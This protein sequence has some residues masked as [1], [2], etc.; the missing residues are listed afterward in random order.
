MNTALPLIEELRA[1][2]GAANVRIADAQPAESLVPN[3]WYPVAAKRRQ[4]GDT[5]PAPLAL[6]SPA[7]A[8][9]VAAVAKWARGRGVSLLPV[10][11]DSNTVGSTSVAQ[12][13]D[14]GATVALSLSRLDT[15]SYDETELSVTAGAGVTLAAV[16][17]QLNA[18]GYTLGSLPQSARLATVGGAVATEAWGLLAA[19]FGGM[20]EQCLALEA[21][22]P[23]GSLVRTHGS[24]AAGRTLHHLLIGTEGA[25]GIVTAATLAMHALPE[26]RAWCAFA[27]PRFADAADALRL[28]YRSDARPAC[29]RLFDANAARRR[30]EG[31]VPDGSAL[32]LF[33]VEGSEIVQNGVY[34]TV[35]AVAK[36]VGGTET[37]ADGDAW[38]GEEQYRTDAW[39]ANGRPGGVADVIS[40]WTGWRS[41]AALHAALTESLRPLTTHIS[42][43]IGFASA[44]GAAL[45]V[46][47]E[48][49]ATSPASAIERHEQ[50]IAAAQR[51][52]L[53]HG[54]AVAHH[55]GIGTARA[56]WADVERGAA[57]TAALEALRRGCNP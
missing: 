53:E 32:L 20:R 48:A 44:H 8:A 15:L 23:D 56:A 51:V 27:Y 28:V 22:L 37:E 39:A 50:I 5:D 24:G 4:G 11:G 41:V 52:T 7:T 54:G 14:G 45:D 9:E 46:R 29:V 3:G 6:A 35:Y 1:I 16:E 12:R 40:V 26:V 18:H 13:Q 21:V 47:V 30:F 19:G 2:V 25:F 55:Y 57:A 33:G 31:A 38:L 36:Q 17:E 34:Q 49:E 10:G 42:V 43:Q